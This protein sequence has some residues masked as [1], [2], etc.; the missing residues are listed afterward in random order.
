M[1]AYDIPETLYLNYK[2]HDQRVRVSGTLDRATRPHNK[3]VLNFIIFFSH[4]YSRRIQTKFIVILYIV[5]INI[6][7]A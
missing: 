4:F 2:I 6:P 1:H 5:E 7:V 3:N